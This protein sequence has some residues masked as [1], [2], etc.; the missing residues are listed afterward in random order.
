MN[1][2]LPEPE[3]ILLV[4]KPPQFTSHD[5]VA[6]LRR[7][8]G[9]KRIGHAG[10]LDPMATGLLIVLIGKATKASQYLVG[11]D[12]EYEGTLELGSVTDSHDCDGRV[13]AT[14]P[15]PPLTEAEMR[16]AMAG[17]L[18]DQM[19]IPPMF[20]AIKKDGVPL[21]KLARKGQEVEREERFVR[22]MRFDLLAFEMPRVRFVLACSKGTY[23]R[24]VAHDLGQRLGCGAHL[25]QLRRTGVERFRIEN[26][27]TLQDLEAL[28][29]ADLRRRLMPVHEA[30]PS[31]WM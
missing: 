15:V 7:R 26:A 20:S 11:L 16:A 24:T 31:S 28:A 13:M 22:I 6:R 30:I 29:D 10:T 19:Q 23:V 17:F 25:V 9:M 5:V 12:K 8:F 14:S 18:G 3:G 1:P 27:L 2:A 4:D 21:Y